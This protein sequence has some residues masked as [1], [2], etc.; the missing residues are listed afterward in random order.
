MV[1]SEKTRLYLISKRFITRDTALSMVIPAHYE[2][3]EILCRDVE[4]EQGIEATT[5]DLLRFAQGLKLEP[6]LLRE[7]PELLLAIG[8]VPDNL[9]PDSLSKAHHV[10]LAS[11]IINA[12]TVVAVVAG[13][14]LSG[15]YLK[16][17]FDNTVQAEQAA[18]A[19]RQQEQLYDDVAKNFPATRIPG[20]DLKTA[21][22]LERAIAANAKTPQR[23][24]QVLSNAIEASPEIEINRL[25]W[26]MTNEPNPKDDDRTGTL[27]VNAAENASLAPGF[28]VDPNFLYEVAFVNGEIRRFNGDYRAALENVNRLAERIQ[29]ESGVAQVVVLQGPVNVSSYSNLQGSTTD[30]RT[31]QQPAALFKLRVTLKHEGAVP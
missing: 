27:V 13:V 30:E 19:T 12:S 25:Y 24:M 18:I 11:R 21:V 29:A 14:A 7:N 3:S 4:L 10:Q 17:S 23:M 15:F 5:I 16:A 28:V 31:A 6:V 9:A 26:V 22:E 20:N 2:N 8:Y 1:E